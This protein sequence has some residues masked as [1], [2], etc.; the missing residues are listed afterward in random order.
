M[1]N[2]RKQKQLSYL[3]IYYILFVDYT[4]ITL[5]N[6][7]LNFIST[8][9][10]VA[11]CSLKLPLQGQREKKKKT[12]TSPSNLTNTLSLI[13]MPQN[14]QFIFNKILNFIKAG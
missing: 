10:R 7:E 6:S 2:Y 5:S 1:N 4:N 8:L 13:H 9:Q 11:D 3:I 12:K 14:F